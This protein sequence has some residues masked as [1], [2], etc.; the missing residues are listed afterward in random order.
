MVCFHSK[1]T[2]TRAHAMGGAGGQNIE[3][4]TPVCVQF[5]FCF[6]FLFFFYYYF[7]QMHF[8]F[9]GKANDSGELS[10]PVTA[11]IYF[12][13][14]SLL[15]MKSNL[16]P[17]FP[18]KRGNPSPCLFCQ[19]LQQLLPKQTLCRYILMWNKTLVW[20]SLLHRYCVAIF[21]FSKRHHGNFSV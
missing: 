15:E 11:L 13:M 3:H 9:I 21:T 8:N 19:Q 12:K 14:Q 18:S 17:Y 7:C 2:D 6:C 4:H 16:L 20:R 1:T 10:C 5:S